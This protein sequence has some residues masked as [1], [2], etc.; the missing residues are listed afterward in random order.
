MPFK[1]GGNFLVQLVFQDVV[2][3]KLSNLLIVSAPPCLEERRVL[4]TSAA[5]EE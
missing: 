5:D 2:L 3:E 1:C 4:P